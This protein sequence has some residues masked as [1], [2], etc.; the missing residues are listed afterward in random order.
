M[1]TLMKRKKQ[2]ETGDII[3]KAISEWYFEHGMSEPN[4]E[5]KTDPEWWIEYLKSLDNQEE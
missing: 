4:W 1:E 5:S 3:R 2:I